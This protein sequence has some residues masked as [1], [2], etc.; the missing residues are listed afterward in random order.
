MN[1]H[2]SEISQ[3]VA[4]GAHAVFVV[5]QMLWHTN[6]TLDIPANITI[7]QLPPRSPELNPVENVWQLR[8]N[9]WLSHRIFRTYDDIVNICC[10]ASH[11]LIDQPWRLMSLGLRQWAHEF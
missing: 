7:M 6:P 11:Q 1:R 5:D 4:P 10:H 3:V 9:T 2:L 8:R